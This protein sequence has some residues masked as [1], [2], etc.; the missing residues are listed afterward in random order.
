MIRSRA[1]ALVAVLAL[2]AA[3]SGKPKPPPDSNPLGVSRPTPGVTRINIVVIVNKVSPP[4]STIKI[5]RGTRLELIL[6]SNVPDKLHVYGYEKVVPV[7]A[8][9]PLTLTFVADRSGLFNVALDKAHLQLCQL[10]VA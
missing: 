9:Y 3:C 4:P 8:G 1:F 5:A 7:Q 2:A 10:R 6:N